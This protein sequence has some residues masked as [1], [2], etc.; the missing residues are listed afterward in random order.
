MRSL[1][2]QPESTAPLLPENTF[3]M[4]QGDRDSLVH[5]V[6]RMTHTSTEGD[7]CVAAVEVDRGFSDFEEVITAASEEFVATRK[8]E[9]E[10]I[11]EI[12][13]FRNARRPAKAR[14]ARRQT[15]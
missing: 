10:L 6:N 15:G 2:L 1:T 9:K 5:G 13:Q 12:I 14:A 3:P 8:A 11:T 7:F 4:S